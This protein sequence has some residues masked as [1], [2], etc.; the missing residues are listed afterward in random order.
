MSDFDKRDY[1][2]TEYEDVCFVCHRPESKAGRMFKL[3]QN[4]CVCDDCMHM[5]MDTM[6]QMDYM[7]GMPPMYG[8]MPGM[9]MPEETEEDKEAVLY[10][11]DQYGTA[12]C[13]AIG[14]KYYTQ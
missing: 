6:S 10:F 1:D 12:M 5:T 14:K 11:I 8:M 3:P 13:K 9:Q 7:T 4:I 2:E